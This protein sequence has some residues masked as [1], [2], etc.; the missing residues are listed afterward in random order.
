LI[1]LLIALPLL[2]AQLGIGL[3]VIS[4]MLAISTR[5]FI[6]AIIHVTGNI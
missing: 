5:A 4:R 1:G 6:E 3:S 2:G